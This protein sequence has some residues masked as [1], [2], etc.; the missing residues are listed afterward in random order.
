MPTSSSEGR[1]IGEGTETPVK[2][3]YDVAFR[4]PEKST[5]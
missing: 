5:N 2:P 1:D 4:S 3:K